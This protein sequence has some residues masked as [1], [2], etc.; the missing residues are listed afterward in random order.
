M[1][2]PYWIGERGD[3]LTAFSQAG[4]DNPLADLTQFD[5]PTESGYLQ[6]LGF[7]TQYPVRFTIAWDADIDYTVKTYLFNAGNTMY[8]VFNGVQTNYAAVSA[9]KATLSVVGGQ[10]NVLQIAHD[11]GP[12]LASFEARLFDGIVG[13]WVDLREV[14]P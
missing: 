13:H 12:G 14:T 8:S 2:S 6:L 11:G 10:R 1:G 3:T 4:F 5:Y 7:T 9:N